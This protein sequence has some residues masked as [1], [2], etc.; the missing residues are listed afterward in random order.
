[1]SRQIKRDEHGQFA[2]G[3]S[4]NPEGARQRRPK[5]LLTADDLDRI[6]LEVASEVVSMRNGKSITRYKQLSLILASGKA[7]NRLAARDFMEMTR[8]AAARR[9]REACRKAEEERR[10]TAQS[11]RQW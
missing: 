10:K 4:G 1:M 2:P 7:A 6:Q 11:G 5:E 3:Q 8:S 9:H